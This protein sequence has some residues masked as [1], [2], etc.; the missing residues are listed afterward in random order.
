MS[1]SSYSP[2]HSPLNGVLTEKLLGLIETACTRLALSV[3][4][5]KHTTFC[6]LLDTPQ[7]ELAGYPVLSPNSPNGPKCINLHLVESG[8]PPAMDTLS[9]GRQFSLKGECCVWIGELLRELFLL[10]AM[11]EL[12]QLSN[13]LR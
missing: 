7:T 9:Q 8:Y 5:H 11:T 1:S 2:L 3:A 4:I 10:E 12:F 13:T 6:F